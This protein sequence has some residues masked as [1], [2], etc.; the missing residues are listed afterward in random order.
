MRPLRFGEREPASVEAEAGRVV[1]MATMWTYFLQELTAWIS[2]LVFSVTMAPKLAVTNHESM[3]V[4]HQAVYAGGTLWVRCGGYIFNLRE[5]D[6]SPVQ[7]YAPD[8]AHDL[9]L[10]DGVPTVVT[11]SVD[12][13][14]WSVRRRIGRH[15]HTLA[16]VAAEDESIAGLC[17]DCGTLSLVTTNRLIEIVGGSTR[18][19]CL[20]EELPVIRPKLFCMHE[21]IYT[22]F[23]H[24]E[25]G[26]GLWSIDRATGA[27][28]VLDR[29][30]E[31]QDAEGEY[32]VSVTALALEPWSPTCLAVALGFVHS[33]G[34][35][36]IVEVCGD[37]LQRPWLEPIAS[38]E[39]AQT[40]DDPRGA[41]DPQPF[42][43]MIAVGNELWATGFD[44]LFRIGS[45]G[46]PRHSALPRFQDF[47]CLSVSFDL[48]EAVLIATDEAT[49]PWMI[50]N[51][52][53]IVSR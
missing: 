5:G 43:G 12:G 53:M 11:C 42:F 47:G 33:D 26:G 52:P 8:L 34:N 2:S 27:V 19:I 51:G 41:A 46:V 25:F 50:G 16:T 32:H 38:P 39:N 44:G 15:W 40:P 28:H 9:S 48:P 37:G 13:K 14:R 24:G 20:S 22:G 45:Q 36:R 30:D 1:A 3:M 10:I 23:D 21:R 31:T 4:P 29:E 18:T 7:V 17:G 35:D 6:A 49:R